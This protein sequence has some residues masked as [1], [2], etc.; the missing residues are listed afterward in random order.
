MKFLKIACVSIVM[1]VSVS[2][3]AGDGAESSTII[4]NLENNGVVTAL[5]GQAKTGFMGPS[6]NSDGQAIAGSVKL[7][8]PVKNSTIITDVENNGAVTCL[9]N[10]TCGSV[11]YDFTE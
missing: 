8:G 9:G 1:S 7:K 4:T 3:F 2:S 5:E 6:V 10:S 11:T